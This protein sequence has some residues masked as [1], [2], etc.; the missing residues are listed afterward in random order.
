MGIDSNDGEGGMSK[1]SQDGIIRAYSILK[2]LRKNLDQIGSIPE[3]YVNEY[4]TVIE[5][6]ENSIGITLSEF[7]IPDS[8]LAPTRTDIRVIVPGSGDSGRARY[9]KEKYVARAFML[10]KMDAILNYFEILTSEKPREI[11]FHKTKD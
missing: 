10:T 9:S 4:H 6:L 7:R 11:G 8:E 1:E 2:A 3:K 5:K